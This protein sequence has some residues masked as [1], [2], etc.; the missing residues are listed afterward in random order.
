M[1]KLLA[2]FCIA[3]L[4]AC[5]SAQEQ[6]NQSQTATEN[7]ETPMNTEKSY[8]DILDNPEVFPTEG[9]GAIF[10]NGNYERYLIVK[11]SNM[12][13]AII[14]VQEYFDLPGRG[15]VELEFGVATIG[16]WAVVKLPAG[17]DHYTYHNLV[18]WQL[19]TGPD[20]PNYADETIGVSFHDSDTSKS[21]IIYNDYSLRQ[22]LNIMDDLFAVRKSNTKMIVSIPFDITLEV[23]LEAI[24]SYDAMQAKYRFNVDDIRNAE[25]E[26]ETVYVTE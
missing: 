23:D 8:A 2:L 26:A 7:N 20:D 16:D 22:E 12:T 25:F 3:I 15:D 4:T 6:G 17:I 1:N 18:Y 19:G 14:K 5:G 10:D 9:S 13:S 11:G 21:Y 24:P